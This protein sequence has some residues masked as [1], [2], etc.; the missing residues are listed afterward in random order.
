MKDGAERGIG[1]QVTFEFNL[2]YRFHSCI[3]ERDEQWCDEFFG[4]V[5]KSTGKPLEELSLPDGMKALGQ[6]EARI[7]K[8]PSK[9]D[10]GGLHRGEDGKF[11]DEDLVRVLKES[12][13][14]PAGRET[15]NMRLA[16]FQLTRDRF[17]WTT[18]HT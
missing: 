7:D 1:N 17:F 10:F 8:D 18:E 11:K 3:S 9:R 2:L 12:M 16:L 5:F 15:Y 4:E 14:D 6:F 13:E